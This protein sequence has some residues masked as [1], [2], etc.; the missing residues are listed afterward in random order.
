M[1][2]AKGGVAISQAIDEGERDSERG[3]IW[4]RVDVIEADVVVDGGFDDEGVLGGR[5]TEICVGRCQDA[6]LRGDKS[7]GVAVRDDV[8]RCSRVDHAGWDCW[9]GLREGIRSARCAVFLRGDRAKT[10]DWRGGYEG[11]SAEKSADNKHGE[12]GELHHGVER[13][14]HG[15]DV[16][17]Q[18]AEIKLCLFKRAVDQTAVAQRFNS[19]SV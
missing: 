17:V 1:N 16:I 5:D 11:E 3:E 6:V 7:S 18:L 12:R 10:K 4:H 19:D 13:K 9:V 8:N 2:K 15:F 14:K